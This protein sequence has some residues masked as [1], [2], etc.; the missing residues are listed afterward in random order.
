MSSMP[1]FLAHF[2]NLPGS[3]CHCPTYQSP[4]LHDWPLQWEECWCTW[5][6]IGHRADA[7]W[8]LTKCS[9]CPE[10]NPTLQFQPGPLGNQQQ[11]QLLTWIA[12]NT[13]KVRTWSTGSSLC[14][15]QLCWGGS[16]TWCQFPNFT[17]SQTQTHNPTSYILRKTHHLP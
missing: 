6:E 2:E 9:V 4:S 10:F 13:K 7:Q 3:Y 14:C 12:E 16:E 17:S 8:L 15:H 5:I 1:I 11:Q